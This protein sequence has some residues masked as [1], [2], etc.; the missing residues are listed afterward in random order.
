MRNIALIGLFLLA[1]L[2]ASCEEE[3]N[4]ECNVITT[5]NGKMKNATVEVYNTKGVQIHQVSTERGI[6]Y[7]K[8]LPSGTFTLKFK[9]ADSNY[10]SAVKIVTL[11]DGDSLPVNV[12][13]SDPP[14]PGTGGG[15][16]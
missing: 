15:D 2:F 7:I 3:G 8:D 11:H 6:A 10:F 4:T 14:D 13:L 1:M 16:E 12:E 9:D 5:L